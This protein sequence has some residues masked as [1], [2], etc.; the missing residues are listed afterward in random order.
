VRR[1]Q[2]GYVVANLAAY[3]AKDLWPVGDAWGGSWVSLSSH[4]QTPCRRYCCVLW[5]A[6][7][8][9]YERVNASSGG[10]RVSLSTF[11]ISELCCHV[12][13][14]NQRGIKLTRY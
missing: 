14:R 10:G 6:L 1:A 13:Q 11:Q 9:L 3:P 2:A 12:L 5:Q 8:L 4:L 7:L